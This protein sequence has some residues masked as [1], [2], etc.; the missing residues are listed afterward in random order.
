MNKK[1]FTGFFYGKLVGNIGKQS[2]HQHIFLLRICFD[3]FDHRS[4]AEGIK[5][6]RTGNFI[7]YIHNL[8]FVIKIDVYFAVQA[9]S[10]VQSGFGK[11]VIVLGVRFVLERGADAD[12][13]EILLQKFFKH[14]AV[15]DIADAV[16]AE[17]KDNIGI[18][19]HI[20]A[21]WK[22]RLQGLAQVV[23]AY[24]G[25]NAVLGLDDGDSL[26][27]FQAV[28]KGGEA[29][30]VAGTRRRSALQHTG[31]QVCKISRLVDTVYG[32]ALHDDAQKPAGFPKR[33]HGNRRKLL[34]LLH[35]NRKKSHIQDI[36]DVDG[37]GVN[38]GIS[39]RVFDINRVTRAA[40]P[41]DASRGAQI[42]N[43]VWHNGMKLML[44][45]DPSVRGHQAA[46][47]RQNV[48][49]IVQNVRIAP[50]YI[51]NVIDDFLQR[52]VEND[53]VKELFISFL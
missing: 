32:V 43:D 15:L 33:L 11:F 5:A 18:E 25:G 14:T 7:Y 40:H 31:K 53:F 13:E 19:Y 6:S 39:R 30:L 45:F 28:V 49:G 35:K 23:S 16:L 46:G 2:I 8:V 47:Y 36:A 34:I 48:Q 41:V 21:V 44:A 50:V 26:V 3:Q 24:S 4:E 22:H 52:S 51:G 20:D 1:L 42:L 17:K 37:S 12:L 38:E 10:Q 9:L 29:V 27:F